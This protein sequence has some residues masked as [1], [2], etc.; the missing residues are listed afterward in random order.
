M[1]IVLVIVSMTSVKAHIVT[2][3][4]Y[5]LLISVIFV[6]VSHIAMFAD[7][8]VPVINTTTTLLGLM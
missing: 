8:Y 6:I 2:I 5:V 7:E 1:L 3:V 4:L